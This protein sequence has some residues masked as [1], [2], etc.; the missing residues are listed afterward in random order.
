MEYVTVYADPS[1]TLRQIFRKAAS[2][3]LKVSDEA[4]KDCTRYC[5]KDTGRLM[6]SGKA[7]RSSGT[8]TW[9]TDYARA[10]YYTGAPD[11]SKNPDASLMWAHKA[12]QVCG[13]KWKALVEKELL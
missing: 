13:A 9:D 3:Q 6:A 7:E 4:L 12:A 2:A 11:R 5:K 8:L 1:E 10:A